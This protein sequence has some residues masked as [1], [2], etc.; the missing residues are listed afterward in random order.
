[1]FISVCLVCVCRATA[2]CFTLSVSRETIYPKVLVLN[3]KPPTL[4]STLQLFY[5]R[6]ANRRTQETLY[7]KMLEGW[8][9][10]MGVELV[11]DTL[12]ILLILPIPTLTPKP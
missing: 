4:N 11:R 3:P 6:T 1:M 2:I 7:A 12:S 5:P 9:K 10:R 8:E